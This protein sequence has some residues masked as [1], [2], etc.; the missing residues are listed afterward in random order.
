VV[1]QVGAE[2]V[3]LAIEDDGR[4][5]DL[6]LFDPLHAGLG[7]FSARA[8]VALVGGELQI[9]TAPGKGMRV[10]ARIPGGARPTE[11]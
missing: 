2:G 1:L 4:G 9:A 3:S 10:V 11:S 6:K 8:V 7:L 5:M